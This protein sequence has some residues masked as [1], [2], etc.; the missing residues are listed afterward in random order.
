MNKKRIII[1]LIVLIIVSSTGLLIAYCYD[2]RSHPF[3]NICKINISQ[4]QK[5]TIQNSGEGGVITDVTDK[6]KIKEIYDLIIPLSYKKDYNQRIAMGWSYWIKIYNK[7]NLK[8][9]DYTF[10]GT[11]FVINNSAPPFYIS[12][13]D[14][15]TQLDNMFDWNAIL[16]QRS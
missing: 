14:I 5:I 6:E 1:F 4:I 16:K 13:K 10:S 12:S 15:T 3:S 2:H 9:A 11:R 7:N 8:V